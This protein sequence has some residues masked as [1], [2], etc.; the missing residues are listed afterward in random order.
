MSVAKV[1]VDIK[2]K[3]EAFK[4]WVESRKWIIQGLG[5]RLEKVNVKE[6][7]HGYHV[8]FKIYETIP[9]DALAV[10]QFLLGDDQK[11]CQ[12][13]FLRAEANVFKQFNALFNN[14]YKKP[15]NAITLKKLIIDTLDHVI[16]YVRSHIKGG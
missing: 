10:L 3:P 16:D 2:L 1:D 4:L 6:T 7:E 5:Y 11:R 13:N 9:D 14:K 8:W 15:G 12:Y